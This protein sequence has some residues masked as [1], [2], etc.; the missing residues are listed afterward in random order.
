A[1]FSSRAVYEAWPSNNSLRAIDYQHFAQDAF[2]GWVTEV[3]DTI[4]AAGSRQLV[5]VG[6]DEGGGFDRPS[7]AFFG[8]A[9]DFTTTHSW[10]ASD[11]LLWDS[12]V[13]KQPGRPMLVQET[14]VSHEVRLDGEAHRS[15]TE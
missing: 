6:Q 15:L 2:R 4:R 8:D 3:R 1:E 10:W 14:G 5:T 7:P 13:A 12:L 9:V 11:A